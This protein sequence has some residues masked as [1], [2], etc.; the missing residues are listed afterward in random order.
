MAKVTNDRKEALEFLG[1]AELGEGKEQK[2]WRVTGQGGRTDPGDCGDLGVK[3]YQG[4]GKTQL[5]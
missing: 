2:R 5:C 4:G 3:L 1:H